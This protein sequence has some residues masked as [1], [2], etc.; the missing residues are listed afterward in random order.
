[1]AVLIQRAADGLTF[2]L[3]AEP[4]LDIAAYAAE[5]CTVFDLATRVNR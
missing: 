1:M 3:A 2:L 5:V 4:E